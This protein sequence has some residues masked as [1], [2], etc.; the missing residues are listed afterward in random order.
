[1]IAILHHQN[2]ETLSMLLKAGANGRL[3]SDEGK[4]AFD[5][6]QQ[7]EDLKGSDAYRQLLE[8]AK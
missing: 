7:D 4:T 3:K 5:Y 1:M 8:A 6:A 2:P